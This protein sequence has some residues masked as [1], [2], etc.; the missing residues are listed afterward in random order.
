MAQKRRHPRKSLSFDQDALLLLERYA[1]ERDI[2][3]STA[4]SEL[5]LHL[6]GQDKANPKLVQEALAKVR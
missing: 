6:A 5:L 3:L 2:K 1:E 4:L